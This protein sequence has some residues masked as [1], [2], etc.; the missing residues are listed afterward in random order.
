MS[1]VG[2]P[3]K[4]LHLCRCWAQA[5]LQYPH[6]HWDLT[7][8]VQVDCQDLGGW[9]Y[10][11]SIEQGTGK[12]GVA[13][14]VWIARQLITLSGPCTEAMG[15]TCWNPIRKWLAFGS[16][17]HQDTFPAHPPGGTGQIL[18]KGDRTKTRSEKY[19]GPSGVLYSLQTLL[20][21][22]YMDTTHNV[23]HKCASLIKLYS[24]N[25]VCNKIYLFF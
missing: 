20:N 3:D 23:K 17:S 18:P 7:T 2:I 6:P 5:E 24:H 8:T 19:T 9:L 11:D 16:T 1:Q 10:G 12:L 14:S 21:A 25:G 4:G 22:G 15:K 13:S